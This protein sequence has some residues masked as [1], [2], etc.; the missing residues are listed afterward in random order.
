MAANTSQDQLKVQIGEMSSLFAQAVG[1]IERRKR[2]P[3]MVAALLKALQ[4][5]KENR[6]GD[7]TLIE[8]AYL[9]DRA[10][11]RKLFYQATYSR[12]AHQRGVPFAELRPSQTLSATAFNRGDR[13]PS[14]LRDLVKLSYSQVCSLVSVALADEIKSLLEPFGL[15]LGMPEI[16][17]IEAF[18]PKR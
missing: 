13:F 15:Y 7:V 18:G 16:E 10:Y 1:Y 8:R 6:L 5:F 9:R 11:L 12:F 2:P 17:S 14:L 3:E 4:L